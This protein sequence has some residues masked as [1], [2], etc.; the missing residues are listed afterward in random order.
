MRVFHIQIKTFFQILDL[1]LPSNITLLAFVP[2]LDHRCELTEL[3]TLGFGVTLLTLRQPM[4]VIPNLLRG[5]PFL[6]EQQVGGDRC[7]V[8]G[9]LWEADDRVEI[10]VG[11]QFLA[12]AFLV[13][14]PRDAA[15]GQYDGAATSTLKQLNKQDDEEVSGFLAPESGGEVCLHAVGNSGS[16]RRIG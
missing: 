3:N 4:F 6:E 12:D 2:P 11:E 13:S 5:C 16:K 8:E 14:V 15:V 9:R 7:G 10:A 1:H